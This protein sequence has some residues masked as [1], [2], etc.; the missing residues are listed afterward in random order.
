[1]MT[2]PRDSPMAA[3]RA[4][5]L[6]AVCLFG[7]ACGTA[8]SPVPQRPPD[9][10][11]REALLSVLGAGDAS[12]VPVDRLRVAT[13]TPEG[14][15]FRPPRRDELAALWLPEH[16]EDVTIESVSCRYYPIWR[17]VFH[18]VVDG[19]P[20]PPLVGEV[21][22]VD[23]VHRVLMRWHAAMH[24]AEGRKVPDF[25]PNAPAGTELPPGREKVMI[26]AQPPWGDLRPPKA[27]EG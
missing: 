15:V 11:L 6:L 12:R 24:D 10:V 4:G 8:R 25:R 7:A 9:E 16:V 27:P 23:G 22:P 21:V 13:L 2:P 5:L 26:V 17:V 14:F 18:P 3:R 19:R 20:G 1:M